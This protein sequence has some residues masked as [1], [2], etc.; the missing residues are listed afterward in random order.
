MTTI[1][2]VAVKLGLN[3]DDFMKDIDK[4]ESECEQ[5]E[6]NLDETKESFNKM[7]K[8]MA[9]TARPSKEM[10]NV[11]QTLK[12]E[13]KNN[14]SAFD[15]LKNKAKQMGASFEQVNPVIQALQDKLI[16]LTK[17]GFWVA[18][19]KKIIDMGKAAIKTAAQFEQLAVSF[20]VLAGGA[21]AGQKLTDQIVALAS[22][23]PLTTEVL[24]N[25]A[26]TLL[27]F[28]EAADEVINDLKLLGDISGGDAQ[29]MQSLTLAFSQIGSQGKLAGQDLLQMINAGFN[30]LEQIS[31]KTGKSI[32][33]LKDEMSKGLITFRDVKQ[34]MIDATAEGG[35]FYGMMNKQSKT[36]EGRISTLSDSWQLIKKNI[37]DFFLPAAKAAV[38]A[39]N[40]MAQA[41]LNLMNKIHQFGVEIRGNTVEGQLKRAAGFEKEA[42]KYSDLAAKELERANA[43]RAK[44]QETRANAVEDRANAYLKHSAK[45]AEAASKAKAASEAL[46]AADKNAN[47]ING[48]FD[49]LSGSGTGESKTAKK[50]KDDT[51]KLEDFVKKY[52]DA[53]LEIQS[54]DI[55]KSELGGFLGSFTVGYQKRLE[56]LKWYHKEHEAITQAHFKTLADQQEA[57]NQL[58]Q[59]KLMQEAQVAKD[60]WTE[61]GEHIA[62]ILNDTFSQML[63][64]YGDFSDNMKQLAINLSTY[65]AKELAKEAFTWLLESQ[66]QQGGII[67]TFLNQINNLS[68]SLTQVGQS[69]Q[70]AAAGVTAVQTAQTAM[71][72]IQAAVVASSAATSASYA[73]EAVAAQQLA[74]ATAQ[75][76]ISEAALSVAKIPFVGGFLAPVA[77]AATGAGIA[78]AV[79]MVSAASL[80]SKVGN[81]GNGLKN[82]LPS[83][84][85]GGM[86]PGT[87]EQV[88]VLQG[89]ERVLNRS[90]AA[91]YNSDKEAGNGDINNVMVF[92]IKAW[93]GRD[94]IDTLKANSQTINQIVS[95]GIKNNNQGLRT[96]VQNT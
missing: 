63:T 42:K 40:A 30:P 90:E 80:F 4:V 86:I 75:L 2:E 3:S 96:I 44:G 47:N 77:A 5:L 33:Q 15:Q 62:G 6:K 32:G 60:V 52:K 37:G 58:E 41:V 65:F 10:K 34:A 53:Q 49:A 19:T 70:V 9:M 91:N 36:L 64:N 18:T 56:I 55:A 24:S 82:V 26:R 73:T 45:F 38:D 8:A 16:Q 29:K 76:A 61:R 68:N 14:Q 71:K 59:T 72:P 88:A 20:E 28:G 83:H 12:E 54:A 69:G 35:R 89:G 67:A 92:N 7:A 46:K 39:L 74:A 87:R 51:V 21:E 31:Q 13:L 81:I 43:L 84:H 48:G 11:F 23:T 85:S 79:A 57:F 22:K 17:V 25:G 94:V 27:S 50:I 1:G 93:D 78:A 95:N 66:K